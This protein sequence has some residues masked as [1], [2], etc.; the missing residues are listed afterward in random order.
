[1]CTELRLYRQYML[2]LMG[3]R[4]ADLAPLLPAASP[5]AIDLIRRLLNYDP[6]QRPSAN[7]CLCHPFIT[8]MSSTVS[9]PVCSPVC[10]APEEFDFDLRKL[11]IDDLRAE[12][13]FESKRS[14][15]L[16]I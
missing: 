6:S 11:S 9:P 12:I 2:S 8:R 1:M 5:D 10:I 15:L 7:A 3:R 16:C 13:A 4:P 14:T